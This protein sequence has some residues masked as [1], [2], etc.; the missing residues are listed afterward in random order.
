MNH[1]FTTDIEYNYQIGIRNLTNCELIKIITVY[2]NLLK[3][4]YKKK[5][6]SEELYK[7]ITDYKYVL[8]K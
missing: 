4:E 7:L 2:R 5:D 3:E 8:D 6:N 1:S